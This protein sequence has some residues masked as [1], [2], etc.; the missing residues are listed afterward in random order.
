MIDIDNVH[1]DEND[2]EGHRYCNCDYHQEL[3]EAAQE[4]NNEND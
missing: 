3:N 2:C 4:Y 1:G